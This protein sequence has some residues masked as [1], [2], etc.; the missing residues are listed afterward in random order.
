MKKAVS[1]YLA[2]IALIAAPGVISHIATGYAQAAPA[3]QIQMDPAEYAAYDD[4]VNKQTTPQTQAPAIE[5]YL[6]KYPKSQVKP[7]LLLRLMIDYSSFDMAK[8]V[9]AADNVLAGDPKNFQAIYLEVQV[10]SAL[11]AAAKDPAVKLTEQDAA[12][13]FGTIGLSLTKPDAIAA[14]VYNSKVIPFFYDAVVTDEF[15]KADYPAVI[16]SVKA[17]LAAVPLAV[18]T[19]PGS[20]LQHTFWLGFAD[21]KLPTPDYVGCTFYATRAATYAPDTYKAQ[22]Q[23]IATYCY[24][25]YHGGTD[26]YDAVVAAAKA[27]LNPP[28]DFKIVPAP[29]DAEIVTKT[30][31]DTP[32]LATLAIDDKEYIIRYGTTEQADKVFATVKDKAEQFKDATVIAATADQLQLAISQDAIANKTADFTFNMKTPLK[33]VP[34]VGSTITITGIWSSYTQKP[35]MITMSDGEVYVKPAPKPVHHT[36]AKKK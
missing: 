23:P 26:G 29:T 24:K 9:I 22:F 34:D 36:P 5:A 14:D 17:E 12:A 18:T 7:E 8:T 4:A 27:N 1:P 10:H 19:V 6:A 2:A 31:A 35:L 33:T 15:L 3:G 30:I 13:K 20:V 25:R 28:A 21:S 32:D 16:A 11:A